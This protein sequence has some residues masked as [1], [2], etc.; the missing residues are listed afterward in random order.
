MECDGD[1][2]DRYYLASGAVQNFGP[3]CAPRTS[4]SEPLLPLL[5]RLCCQHP[6]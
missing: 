2:G 1:M 5:A 6:A 4:I 3:A